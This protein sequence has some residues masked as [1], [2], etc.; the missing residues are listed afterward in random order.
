MQFPRTT[1]KQEDQEEES[2]T[3]NILIDIW[4]TPDIRMILTEI[5]TDE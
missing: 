5:Q 2:P 3:D 4:Y 1:S